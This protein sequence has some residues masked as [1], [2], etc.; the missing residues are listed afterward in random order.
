MV[1][2]PAL[3]SVEGTFPFDFAPNGL[4]DALFHMPASAD[5][6]RTEKLGVNPKMLTPT[7]TYINFRAKVKKG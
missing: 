7:L 2:R 3:S 5:A 4:S 1:A 6:T